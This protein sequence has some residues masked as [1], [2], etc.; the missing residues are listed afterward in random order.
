[1]D[2]LEIL[3]NLKQSNPTTSFRKNIINDMQSAILCSNEIQAAKCDS[4]QTNLLENSE[5]GVS[6]GS[7]D[8]CSSALVRT[9]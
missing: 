2:F 8:R 4:V 6:A 9:D 1:M 7:F 5:Y 3:K